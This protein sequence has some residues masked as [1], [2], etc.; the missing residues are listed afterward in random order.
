LGAWVLQNIIVVEEV[1]REREVVY[2]FW[3]VGQVGDRE[4]EELQCSVK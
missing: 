1:R 4:R 3:N 2:C